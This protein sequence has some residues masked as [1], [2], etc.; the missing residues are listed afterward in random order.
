[1]NA[2]A[3]GARLVIPVKGPFGIGGGRLGCTSR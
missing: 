1:M 2:Q 3:D